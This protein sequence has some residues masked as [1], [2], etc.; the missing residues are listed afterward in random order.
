MTQSFQFP[1]RLS[2]GNSGDL[3]AFSLPPGAPSRN[4]VLEACLTVVLR[5][6]F[7]FLPCSIIWDSGCGQSCKHHL[8][9]DA[10]SWGGRVRLCPHLAWPYALYKWLF[11]CSELNGIGPNVPLSP[12]P[13]VLTPAPCQRS[14]EKLNTLPTVMASTPADGEH[15]QEPYSTEGD[16]GTPNR[17]L[18]CQQSG[19]WPRIEPLWPWLLRLHA[20]YS[21]SR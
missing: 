21:P 17:S 16:A 4:G 2:Q 10:V 3:H 20:T 19:P 14:R 6:P 9:A 11:N 1:G 15:R 13:W 7:T 8:P 18:I 5:S 12:H